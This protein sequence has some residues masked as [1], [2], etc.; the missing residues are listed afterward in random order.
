MK[1]STATFF[2]LATI[3]AAASNQTTTPSAAPV[4]QRPP[5][6]QRPP[7]PEIQ[8]APIPENISIK[9]VH[10]TETNILLLFLD[11]KTGKE[12]VA[13]LTFEQAAQMGLIE[14]N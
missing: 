12:G 2:A 1:L 11:Q 3:V 6:P 5:A 7:M 4:P 10:A 8:N 9:D 13:V 14:M